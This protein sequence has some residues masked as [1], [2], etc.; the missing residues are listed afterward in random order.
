[1]EWFIAPLLP[2][3]QENPYYFADADYY[4]PNLAIGTFGL[5]A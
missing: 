3:A 4:H 1:M 5:P 2:G